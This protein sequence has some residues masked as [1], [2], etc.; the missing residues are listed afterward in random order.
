MIFPL[1]KS[2]FIPRAPHPGAFGV[3]RRYEVHTGVDLY[4]APKTPVRAMAGGL[5][6]DVFPFTGLHA[7]SAWWLDT[8]A[9]LIGG[10]YTINYGEC[11]PYVRVGD[12]VRAGEIIGYVIPVLPPHKLRADIPHHSTSMLHLEMYTCGTRC[13]SQWKLGARQPGRLI[14]PT[15]YLEMA[16]DRVG[17]DVEDNAIWSS[18]KTPV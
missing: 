6:I 8:W 17:Q 7:D 5:V 1:L 16:L 3:N 10:T 12:N 4:C 13:C 14:D 9:I 15:S 11:V 2:A 18:T